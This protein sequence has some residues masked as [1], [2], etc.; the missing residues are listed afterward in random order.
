MST[1][2]P[3][4]GCQDCCPLATTVWL[5][6]PAS[7]AWQAWHM[8]TVQALFKIARRSILEPKWLLS[9]HH[10]HEDDENHVAVNIVY[11]IVHLKL[12]RELG[13]DNEGDTHNKQHAQQKHR[14]KLLGSSGKGDT[15]ESC[16]IGQRATRRAAQ[17]P[18][19]YPSSSSRRPDLKGRDTTQ[20]CLHQS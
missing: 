20:N 15:D 4:S 6:E 13:N 17:T 2:L 18:S 9:L 11:A 7:Q 14:R 10:E 3:T 8:A 5:F 19:Q 16:C 1:S 12:S